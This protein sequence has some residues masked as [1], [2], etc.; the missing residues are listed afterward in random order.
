MSF[1]L[2]ITVRLAESAP[3]QPEYA[4]T[5]DYGFDLDEEEVGREMLTPL[6]VGI[7]THAIAE[8]AAEEF[9]ARYLAFLS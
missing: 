4:S 6:P 3:G 9:E 5:R 8:V 7:S 2:S 1:N